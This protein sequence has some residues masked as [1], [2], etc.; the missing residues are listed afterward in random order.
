M[1]LALHSRPNVAVPR[2]LP[3]PLTPKHLLYKVIR[4][5]KPALIELMNNTRQLQLEHLNFF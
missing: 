5:V 2:R 1:L 4:D 3:F